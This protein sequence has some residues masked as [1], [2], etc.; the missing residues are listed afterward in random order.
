MNH[1]FS[2]SRRAGPSPRPLS[3]VLLA[4]VSSVFAAGYVFTDAQGVRAA[5]SVWVYGFTIPLINGIALGGLSAAEG[6]PP[7]LMTPRAA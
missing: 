7:W 6:R 3:G 2:F 1:L 4:A 5:R